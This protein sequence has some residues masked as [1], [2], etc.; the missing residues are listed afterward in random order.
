MKCEKRVNAM[1]R[2]LA[3]A[4]VPLISTACKNNQPAADITRACLNLRNEIDRTRST[5]LAWSTTK[6]AP[7]A[8]VISYGVSMSERTFSAR[9]V[10][11]RARFCLHVRDVPDKQ[12]ADLESRVLDGAMGFSQTNDPAE[13]HG[14][15]SRLVVVLDDVNA[16]PL[17][18]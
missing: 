6:T 9:Q 8:T 11:A 18:D 15:L 7:I 17:L 12:R 1:W 3:L 16:L 14:A 2:A 10:H 5:Y 13:M 4:L